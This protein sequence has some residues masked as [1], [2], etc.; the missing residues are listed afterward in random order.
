M[1][2]FLSGSDCDPLESP[3]HLS[4]LIHGDASPALEVRELDQLYGRFVFG[5]YDVLGRPR[6]CWRVAFT[7]YAC[8]QTPATSDASI[9]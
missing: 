4:Y 3:F 9:R 6:G 5:F 2:A 7:G 8:P 1:V